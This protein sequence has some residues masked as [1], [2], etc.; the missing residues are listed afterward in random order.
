MSDPH[1]PL[2]PHPGQSAGMVALSLPFAP[3]NFSAA[4]LAPANT[5]SAFY[6][7]A[8]LRSSESDL[9]YVSEL[10]K[11]E[12]G[13][14]EKCIHLRLES[15]A[16]ASVILASRALI[17]GEESLGA[18]WP[19]RRKPIP[20]PSQQAGREGQRALPACDIRR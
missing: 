3:A 11:G 18:G 1:L 13:V 15:E 7:A 8:Y 20:D 5:C 10:G 19:R 12:G 16:Q 9:Y 2:C 14:Q 17:Q 6:S 4:S